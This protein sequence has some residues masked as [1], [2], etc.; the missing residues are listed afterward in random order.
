M[1]Y[2]FNSIKIPVI[3][4]F[5][6]SM[7][8]HVEGRAYILSSPTIRCIRTHLGRKGEGW[9]GKAEGRIRLD[10]L[11]SGLFSSPSHSNI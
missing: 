2:N 1:L 10:F 4:I 11:V 8:K 7:E 9:S 3:C 5:L 6:T